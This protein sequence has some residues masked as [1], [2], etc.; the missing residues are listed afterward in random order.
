MYNYNFI[1]IIIAFFLLINIIHYIRFPYKNIDCNYS[2]IL[3]SFFVEFS[4]EMFSRNKTN[5]F[6]LPFFFLINF[7]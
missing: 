3:V 5:F 1:V 4:Y 2:W 6:N 7:N